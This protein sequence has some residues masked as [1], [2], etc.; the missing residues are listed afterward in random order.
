MYEL[1]EYRAKVMCT[2]CRCI[3][4]IDIVLCLL[5]VQ[6]QYSAVRTVAIYTAMVYQLYAFLIVY[7]SAY[8]E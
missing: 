2:T 4:C 7:Y 6:Y 8:L 5:D 3:L 1:C